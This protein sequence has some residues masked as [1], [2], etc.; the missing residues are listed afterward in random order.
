[1]KYQHDTNS[2]RHMV[3]MLKQGEDS[4]AHF[5]SMMLIL[6][7]TTLNVNTQS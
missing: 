2:F 6:T 1:M 4:H 5:V 3:N 7:V